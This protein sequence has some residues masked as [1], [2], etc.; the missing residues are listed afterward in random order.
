MVL[1][2]NAGAAVEGDWNYGADE[3]TWVVKSVRRTVLLL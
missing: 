3:K 1:H 2:S